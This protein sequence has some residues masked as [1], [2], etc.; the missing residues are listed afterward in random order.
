MTLPCCFEL[1]GE[2]LEEVAEVVA[3][4]VEQ[5]VV[6]VVREEVEGVEVGRLAEV[7][8]GRELQVLLL[9][10]ARDGVLVAEDEVELQQGARH[11]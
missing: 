11:T 7:G 1:G 3:L 5:D 8:L 9:E 10:L 6:G 2:V 4:A